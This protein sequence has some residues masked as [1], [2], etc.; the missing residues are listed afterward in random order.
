M[1]EALALPKNIK[2][3]WRCLTV[4][5]TLAYYTT[6]KTEKIFIAQAID[7]DKTLVYV[8]SFNHKHKY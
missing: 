4:S 3:R 6:I 7:G 5:Y 2:L 1:Q 8:R